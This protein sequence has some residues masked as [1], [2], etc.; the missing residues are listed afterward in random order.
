MHANFHN[1]D[2][3]GGG[4]GGRDDPPRISKLRV[5]ELSQK[6]KTSG[7]LSTSSGVFFGHRSIFDP[8]MTGERSNFRKIDN[9]SNL[10]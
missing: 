2:V 10:H 9:F 5:V 1:A 8:V 7:L 6:K 3:Q 4:G